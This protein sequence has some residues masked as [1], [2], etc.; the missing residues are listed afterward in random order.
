MPPAHVPRVAVGGWL[1][2]THTFATPPTTLAMFQAQCAV[3]GDAMLA[4]LGGSA[5]GIGGMIDGGR[6]R[7]WSLHGTMYA[8]AMPGGM[9]TA[10]ARRAIDD[11]RRAHLAAAMPL[12]GVLL[13]LH[14]AAVAADSQRPESDLLV[15]VRDEIKMTIQAYQ[16]LY[17]SSIA[18]GMR[19]AL[20]AEQS[21]AEKLLQLAS[22]EKR[23]MEKENEI[24]DL[25]RRINDKLEDE[26]QEKL[27]KE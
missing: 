26:K 4:Q 16:T 10:D 8:A 3:A 18:Y 9:V 5:A 14:G 13:A 17:E 15:R 11:A 23:C 2:E 19:K 6:A 22:L 25:R 24:N 7:G 27:E 1:H 21:K 20:Q 12:V